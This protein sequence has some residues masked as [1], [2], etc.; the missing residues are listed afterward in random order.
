[1]SGAL[2]AVA[3]LALWAGPADG[4]TLIEQPRAFTTLVNPAC[5]HCKD[6]AKR[7][8]EDLKPTDRVLCWTRGKYDGGAIPFRFFLNP[9]RVVSDTYGVFVLDA[10]AGF[11]RGFKPSLDFRFHGWRNGVMVMRHTDG[12]LYSCLSG[13]AFAGPNKGK[14]L[15]PI[16]TLVSDWGD[17]LKRYPDTVAY[18]MFDK[19]KPVDLPARRSEASIKS[20]GKVDKRLPA[21][22][23]VLG[24]NAGKAT[25]A[26]RIANLA[27]AHLVSDKL[28]GKEIVILWNEGTKTASAYV[29]E[30]HRTTQM[31][32]QFKRISL[33]HDPKVAAAPFKDQGSD[34]R[35]D[36]AGRCVSGEHKGWTLRWLD[37]VQVKWYAWAAEYPDTTSHGK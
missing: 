7:R 30:I 34:S 9:Y 17:W 22:E 28:G 12:T 18:R 20:R 10:D 24:V 27:R 32:E 25:K 11:A 3:G 2:L 1:M 13:V 29:A 26:Y 6:E 36:Y 4:P 31:G 15:E 35:F 23:M 8:K 37:S 5:S 21:G 33:E 14:R 16:P 19:Y